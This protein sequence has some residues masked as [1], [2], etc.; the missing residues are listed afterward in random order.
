MEY[1]RPVA[2]VKGFLNVDLR[3]MQILLTTE[4]VPSYYVG[5]FT[6][7]G[8]ILDPYVFPHPIINTP[9]AASDIPPYEAYNWATRLKEL[10]EIRRG[11]MYLVQD[12]VKCL[13]MDQNSECTRS[14]ISVFRL[15][16]GGLIP[17]ETNRALFFERLHPTC[18]PAVTQSE[19]SFLRSATYVL[20][21][22][23]AYRA[24]AE[25]VDY[26]LR[27][28]HYDTWLITELIAMEYLG[29]PTRDD[30][31]LSFIERVENERIS[32]YYEDLRTSKVQAAQRAQDEHD[33]ALYDAK[34]E[35]RGKKRRLNENSVESV[36][37]RHY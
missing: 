21:N 24:L 8:G 29:D 16:D 1:C 22:I 6:I 20:R 9:N 35:S 5:R 15:R 4:G 2:R 3:T 23:P 10:H 30:D 26:H 37:D 11:T 33:R 28:A 14:T 36:S 17:T 34:H 27:T 12:V 32:D 19:A 7:L 18:N 25:A 31:T 13:T